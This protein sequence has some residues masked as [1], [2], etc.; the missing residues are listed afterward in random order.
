MSDTNGERPREYG[1]I[2]YSLEFPVS[3]L[4]AVVWPPRKRSRMVGA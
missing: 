4:I 1:L 3:P 2:E